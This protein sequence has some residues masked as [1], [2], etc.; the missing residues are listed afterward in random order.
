MPRGANPRKRPERGRLCGIGV[1]NVAGQS[2]H[3]I[4]FSIHHTGND[5]FSR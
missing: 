4:A 2:S 3:A 5:H 1:I